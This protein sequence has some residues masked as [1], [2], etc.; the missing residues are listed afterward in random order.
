M[1]ESCPAAL[2]FRTADRAVGG[3]VEVPVVQREI[4][5]ERESRME[6]EGG[7]DGE[8]WRSAEGVACKKEGDGVGDCGHGC[9]ANRAGDWA[10]F[11]MQVFSSLPPPPPS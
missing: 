9:E 11:R 5:R 7:D 4:Q 8:T 6:R 10:F 1:D 2:H 3:V